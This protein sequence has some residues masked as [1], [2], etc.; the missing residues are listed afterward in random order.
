MSKIF[1]DNERFRYS[2]TKKNCLLLLSSL[3]SIFFLCSHFLFLSCFLPV[4]FFFLTVTFPFLLIF[5]LSHYVYLPLLSIFSVGDVFFSA[6]F[7]LYF[8]FILFFKFT[9]PFSNI[10]YALL[11][12]DSLASFPVFVFIFSFSVT[13]E[14]AQR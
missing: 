13:C 10:H 3:L 7:L 6:F 2:Y 4:F 8:F 9:S 5:Y 14:R 12:L 1:V 11:I